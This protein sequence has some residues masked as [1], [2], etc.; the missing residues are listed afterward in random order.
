MFIVPSIVVEFASVVGRLIGPW[1]ARLVLSVLHMPS[2]EAFLSRATTLVIE[3]IVVGAVGEE[4][5]TC[6]QET[7]H[8]LG[9][10]K[11]KEV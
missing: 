4:E 5:V 2:V 6:G 8:G 10:I 9:I 7:P 3:A 1:V 11:P